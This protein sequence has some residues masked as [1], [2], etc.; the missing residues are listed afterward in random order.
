MFLRENLSISELFSEAPRRYALEA[1]KHADVI[2]C[3]RKADRHCDFGNGKV[4]GGEEPYRLIH[5]D[6][7]K[8]I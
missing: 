7:V 3:R 5:P 6:A 8:V 1:F 4:G 2:A